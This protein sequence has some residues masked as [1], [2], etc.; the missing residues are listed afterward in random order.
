MPSD[1]RRLTRGDFGF[2]QIAELADLAVGGTD[3]RFERVE[4]V[5]VLHRRF[6][7]VQV[8]HCRLRGGVLV[9]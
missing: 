4:D 5:R 3:L 8:Q 1:S 7:L 9:R 6:L 2:G